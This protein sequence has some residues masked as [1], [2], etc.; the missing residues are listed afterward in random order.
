[1]LFF[2]W[3]GD[4]IDRTATQRPM[5]PTVSA[6]LEPESRWSWRSWWSTNVRPGSKLVEVALQPQRTPL[7]GG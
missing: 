1:M 2:T 5:Q 4:Q 7:A 3:L 6:L